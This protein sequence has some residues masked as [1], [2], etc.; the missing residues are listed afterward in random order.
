MWQSAWKAFRTPKIDGPDA[1]FSCYMM[2]DRQVF[3]QWVCDFSFPFKTK[4]SFQIN[5]ICG[6]KRWGIQKLFIYFFN[7]QMHSRRLAFWYVLILFYNSV[8]RG[9]SCNKGTSWIYCLHSWDSIACNKEFDLFAAMTQGGG[10]EEEW[11]HLGSC[12][13]TG[14]EVMV[15]SALL[16]LWWHGAEKPKPPAQKKILWERVWVDMSISRPS[17]FHVCS[18]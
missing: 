2:D 18:S 12:L 10:E 1:Q 8:L 11:S 17:P 15:T 9:R 4:K 5:L 7:A 3:H 16:L 14:L 6:R 13:M